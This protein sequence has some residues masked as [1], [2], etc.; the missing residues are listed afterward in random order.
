MISWKL[1]ADEL[2]FYRS[3]VKSRFEKGKPFVLWGWKRDKVVGGRRYPE[4]RTVYF[5]ADFGVKGDLIFIKRAYFF[6]ETRAKESEIFQI[7][8]K[9]GKSRNLRGY[10]LKVQ[11]WQD[12]KYKGYR[13]LR[14]EIGEP[15]EYDRSTVERR[16]RGKPRLRIELPRVI[17][18]TEDYDV[19]KYAPLALYCGSGLSSESG[20]PLL[21]TI[22]EIFE[23]DNLKRGE[24][25]FGARDQLPGR[26]VGD[27]QGQ[28]KKFC[29][30]SID[31]IRARP[32]SSHLLLADLYRKGIVKQVF[33]DNVDDI[34]KKVG[35]PFTQTRLS[36]FPD[37]FAVKFDP[38]VR[39]LMVIGIAVDRRDVIKQARRKGLK[40][41]SINPLYGVAPYSRNMDYLCSGDIFYKGKAKDV[42]PKI[43]K[44]LN[45]LSKL[46][47]YA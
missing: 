39:A 38:K 7:S 30:F 19:G 20:L 33:S 16:L 25:I 45:L 47:K 36:I 42:L 2:R 5:S 12:V 23:V 10:K 28:F 40:I 18:K 11:E 8:A 3:V 32:S 43:I 9:I 41:I 21:G 4:S 1:K 29:Q 24:L 31:S 15:S 26:V 44:R 22:H 37:R 13:R 35:V 34:L 27:L 17:A 6:L 46:P 14:M